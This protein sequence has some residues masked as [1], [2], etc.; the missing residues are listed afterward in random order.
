M[1]N[2]QGYMARAKAQ[3]TESR[4]ME[5]RIRQQDVG[6]YQEKHDAIH[7]TAFG[8]AGLIVVGAATASSRFRRFLRRFSLIS[9]AFGAFMGIAVPALMGINPQAAH[10][11]YA[12][13]L[14]L[15]M[16]GFFLLIAWVISSFLAWAIK[17][18]AHDI[19]HDYLDEAED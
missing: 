12:A 8:P 15:T 18:I 9:M 13:W 2:Y 1:P 17:A 14:L 4:A 7:H 16:M 10:N 19:K 3:L 5:Q 6:R 11:P